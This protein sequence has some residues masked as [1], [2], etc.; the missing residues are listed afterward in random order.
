[1]EG[2]ISDNGGEEFAEFG[3]VAELSGHISNLTDGV[4]HVWGDFIEFI[5][6]IQII[7]LSALVGVLGDFRI[8][9]LIP[10]H[11]QSLR[12]GGRDFLEVIFFTRS[13]CSILNL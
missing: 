12:R 6:Q 9:L 8:F 2:G 4:R 10:I 1:V 3:E 5:I 11:L 7:C 13:S